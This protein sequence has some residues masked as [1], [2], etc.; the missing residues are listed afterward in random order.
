MKVQVHSDINIE[1]SDALTRT[2]DTAIHAALDRYSHRIPRAEVRLSADDDSNRNRPEGSRCDLEV[3]PAGMEL[4]V[5]GTADTPERACHDAARKMQRLLAR[6]FEPTDSHNTGATFRRA[7]AERARRA[8]VVNDHRRLHDVRRR[9]RRIVSATPSPEQSP[10][11]IEQAV[12]ELTSAL[13]LRTTPDRGRRLPRTTIIAV[14]HP[15]STIEGQPRPID[16]SPAE[17]LADL[18]VAVTNRMHDPL[19]R[20]AA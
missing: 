9:A 3:Q 7:D 12:G 16:L 14:P 11:A 4:V 5:T 6:T 2:V 20:S 17:F 13:L 8:C 1:G 10:V 19:D 15:T 18:E